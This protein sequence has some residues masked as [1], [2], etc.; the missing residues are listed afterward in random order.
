MC[1]RNYWIW[2]CTKISGNYLFLHFLGKKVINLVRNFILSD[3]TRLW[4]FKSLS[5]T[6]EMW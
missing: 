5:G 4:E 2:R 6:D 1:K 3:G